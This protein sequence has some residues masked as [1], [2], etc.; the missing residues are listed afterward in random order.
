MRTLLSLQSDFFVQRQSELLESH[1]THIRVKS[2]GITQQTMNCRIAALEAFHRDLLAR[3]TASA[4]RLATLERRQNALD[5]SHSRIETAMS[6]VRSDLFGLLT[7]HESSNRIEREV[8]ELTKEVHLIGS[9]SET[10]LETLSR[11][12]DLAEERLSCQTGKVTTLL[13]LVESVQKESALALERLSQCETAFT[14]LKSEVSTLRSLSESAQIQFTAH[15]TK[16]NDIDRVTADFLRVASEI[17][18]LQAV[19]LTLKSW[20][21]P[22]MD[23]LI[24]GEF[25]PL[26]DEFRWKQFTL[27]WRGSRDGFGAQEFHRRCDGR[28][29]T[30][31]LILDTKGNVFGGFTPVKWE[32]SPSWKYKSDD[33]LRSFLFTLRNPQGIPPRKFTLRAEWKERGIEC[34]SA[35]G[36]RF[37]NGCIYVSDNCNENTSSHTAGFGN[38]YHSV[39]GKVEKEFLT[40]A[41]YFRVKEIEVLEIAD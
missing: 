15:E 27:L 39:S 17:G 10:A 9:T 40:G 6:D 34:W 41:E 12:A 2:M 37:G 23:S 31:T 14:Q 20:M 22:Q 8:T 32:S 35:R 38:E 16:F 7:S 5:N 21:T 29:N 26:F 33:S 19:S 3:E 30:L 11:R 13:T 4:T 18:E 36:P 24:I 25:P 28:A 1:E